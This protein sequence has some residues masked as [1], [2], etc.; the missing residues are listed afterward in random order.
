MTAKRPN[1]FKCRHF[2]ITHEPNHPYGC[3]AMAFK[4]KQLPALVVH[5]NSGLECQLFSPKE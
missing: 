1:C 4:S 5:L 2:F 3:H